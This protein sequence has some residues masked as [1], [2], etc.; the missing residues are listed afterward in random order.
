MQEWWWIPLAAVGFFAIVLTLNGIVTLLGGRLLSGG[1]RLVIG[2][3]LSW[4]CLGLALL[5]LNLQTYPSVSGTEPVATLSFKR[6]GHEVFDATLARPG[7]GGMIDDVRIYRLSGRDWQLSA[8]TLSWG[9]WARGLGLEHHVRLEALD[10]FKEGE[11][12]LGQ[13]QGQGQHN[14]HRLH[15]G[16]PSVMIGALALPWRPTVWATTQRLSPA[17]ALLTPRLDQTPLLPMQDE[18]RYE[19]SLSSSGLTARQSPITRTEER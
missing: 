1:L 7:R 14:A 8:R 16:E 12:G 6:V 13:G 4:A 3:G 15:D 17:L 18:S 19:I 9:R 11:S 5:G 10:G 2:A